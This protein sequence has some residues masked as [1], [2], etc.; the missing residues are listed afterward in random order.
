METNPL[1][2]LRQIVRD[3]FADSSG[4][5]TLLSNENLE[6]LNGDAKIRV[7]STLVEVLASIDLGKIK[8]PT[9]TLD[10]ER[11]LIP[12]MSP[13]LNPDDTLLGY[14]AGVFGVPS[15]IVMKDYLLGLIDFVDGKKPVVGG[16][17][18]RPSNPLIQYDAVMDR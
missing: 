14:S 9:P 18:F 12:S 3:N 6:N 5:L 13:N 15:A 16:R 17:R 8:L 1:D 10:V 11:R 7:K 2:Y 4:E